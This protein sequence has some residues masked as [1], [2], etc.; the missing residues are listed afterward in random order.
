[1]RKG[2]SW[3]QE[4]IL[5]NNLELTCHIDDCDVCDAGG[6]VSQARGALECLQG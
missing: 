4:L 3:T 2:D 5:S 1:M 6:E